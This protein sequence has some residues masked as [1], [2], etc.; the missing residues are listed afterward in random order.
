MPLFTV[1]QII[2]RGICQSCTKTLYSLPE[3]V[4][5]YPDTVAL[6][7]WRHTNG[8]LTW[9][10]LR[11][12]PG[13][14]PYIVLIIVEKCWTNPKRYQTE[15]GRHACKISL[16]RDRGWEMSRLMTKPAKWLCAHRRL[17]IRNVWSESS[18]CAQ[19]VAKDQSFLHADS[20]DSDQTGWMPFCW[21]CDEA[22]QIIHVYSYVYL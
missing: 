2:C 19:W 16:S 20:E 9:Q 18:L 1:K 13:R 5:V 11:L 12:V 14:K 10:L 22:A 3:F 7:C 17:S 21:F 6:R 4:P 15:Y 8:L